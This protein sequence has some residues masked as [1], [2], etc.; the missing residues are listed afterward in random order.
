V[1]VALVMVAGLLLAVRPADVQAQGGG[2]QWQNPLPTGN[3]LF[4]VWGSSGSDV[5][6]V[7]DGGAILHYDGATWSAMRSGT[8][9]WLSGV[10]GSSGSDVFAVGSNFTV[11]HYDGTGWSAMISGMDYT[12][13]DVWGSNGGG[14]LCRGRGVA[15]LSH[16]PSL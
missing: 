12:L 6:A 5:F 10:W 13:H 1:V 2:W 15:F 11:L 8:T 3:T 16:H 9:E 14:R 4:G 7:G